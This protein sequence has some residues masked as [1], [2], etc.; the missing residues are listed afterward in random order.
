MCN[1]QNTDC[2]VR[3]YRSEGCEATKCFHIV[4]PNGRDTED[5]SYLKCLDAL[6]PD[7]A[8]IPPSGSSGGRGG[9]GGGGGGR[10]GGGGGG[11]RGRG[12][13]GRGR[14]RG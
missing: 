4:R 14:G 13:R 1:P 6:Y 2:Q 8:R 9:R 3:A 7:N 11:A 5:F 10:R 12:G